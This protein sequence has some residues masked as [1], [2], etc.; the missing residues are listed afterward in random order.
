M[1]YGIDVAPLG[2]DHEQGEMVLPPQDCLS[3]R[4]GRSPARAWPGAP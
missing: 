2:G 4:E 1:R 3:R